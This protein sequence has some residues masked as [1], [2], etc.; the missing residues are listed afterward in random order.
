M[1]LRRENDYNT[2]P[3]AKGGG[4]HRILKHKHCGFC[5][6]MF[7]WRGNDYCMFLRREN[8]YNT[9]PIAKRRPT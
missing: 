6:F 5:L 3:I 9:V 4:Q 8:D 7:L 2:V 1:F